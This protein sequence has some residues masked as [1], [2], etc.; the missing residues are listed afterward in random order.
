MCV[1]LVRCLVRRL[2]GCRCEV[3]G[4][5]LGQSAATAAR[6]DGE[7]RRGS[8][9]GR[10]R[11]PGD[12]VGVGVD[13]VELGVRRTRA[14]RGTSPRSTS[15]ACRQVRREHGDAP[16]A[17]LRRRL[18]D[19]D[20][21]VE[22]AGEEALGD[23]GGAEDAAVRE[24]PVELDA[25]V[26]EHP[27]AEAQRAEHA[28]ELRAHEVR[29]RE[30]AVGGADE[31]RPPL[32]EPG[33]RLAREVVVGEQ[34]AGVR[35]ALEGLAE[36]RL[37]HGIG[38]DRRRR[39]RRRTGANRP[40][41]AASS[42]APLLQ[43]TIATGSPAGVVTR[44]SSWWACSSG[45]SS[46]TIAKMLVPALTLPVRGATEFVATM[47]VPAS[48]SGGQNATPGCSAPDGSSRAAPSARQL[49]RPAGPPAAPRAAGRRGAVRARGRRRARRTPRAARRRSRSS[50]S[51]SGTCP[52]RRRRRA[53]CGP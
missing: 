40:T 48:P 46:T 42:L 14:R 16:R 49:A 10:R 23:A 50:R 27:H 43:C 4:G 15:A 2:V 25:L 37:E 1:S 31:Q 3:G 13:G 8:G 28:V 22:R 45:R 41:H 17:A 21:R 9:R 51:R 18:A 5:A 38:V 52:R 34:A 20:G 44:S 30:P 26:G 33:D 39:P 47:P 6:L 19:R 29:E 7:A 24:H 11:E 36:Q 35:L 32:G 12:V 53:P